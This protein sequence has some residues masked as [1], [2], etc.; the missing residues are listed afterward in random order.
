MLGKIGQLRMNNI[1]QQANAFNAQL[2]ATN[3]RNMQQRIMD[4][5]A[6]TQ[7]NQIAANAYMAS[8]QQRHSA[9]NA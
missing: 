1:D 7:N 8:D 4:A 3:Q 6:R 9:N 5:Q 2:D